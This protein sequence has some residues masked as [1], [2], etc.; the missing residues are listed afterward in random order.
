AAVSTIAAEDITQTYGLRRPAG[1]NLGAAA[2]E[3]APAG[4][5]NPRR[6]VRAQLTMAL[7]AGAT[8]VP[9]PAVLLSGGSRAKPVTVT[10]ADG[11][12]AI[13]QRVL[14]TTGAYGATL[15][16]VRLPLERRLRTVALLELARPGPELPVL[17]MSELNR[18]GMSGI[19]WV[20]PIHYPDGRIYLKIGGDPPL[21]PS[22]FEHDGVDVASVIA[23]WFQQGGS[24]EE[25]AE[26][27]AV[28]TEI[29]PDRGVRLVDH[30]PCV[31]TYTPDDRPI[32]DWIDDRIALAV[33]G[34]GS[35][36]KSADAIGEDAARLVVSPDRK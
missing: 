10:G 29:L 4:F 31:V 24:E 30:K 2:H 28:A 33:G 1:Y 12:I 3:L 13:A 34:C 21:A 5:I 27:V 19:Y 9:W 14:L 17:I 25:V 18:P 7:A 20:P 6:M 8:L 26:L 32:M 11:T 36:G 22:V 23:Q 16:G 15:A 35:A